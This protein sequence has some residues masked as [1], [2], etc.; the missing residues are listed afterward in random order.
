M[1]RGGCAANRD[2]CQSGMRGQSGHGVGAY[3]WVGAYEGVCVFGGLRGWGGGGQP[4]WGT[5]VA[6][7][8]GHS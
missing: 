7:G 8:V 6:A 3:E 5:V 4:G 1:E 2:V